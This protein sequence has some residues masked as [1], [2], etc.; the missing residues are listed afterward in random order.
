MPKKPSI[1]QYARR[2]VATGA[3][4]AKLI[5]TTSIVTAQ[6]VRLKCQY[7]CGGYGQCLTCP[8]YSPPPEK[9]A[10]V[11]CEYKKALLVHGDGHASIRA[12][13]I[14]LEREAFLD[15]Y[16]K[17]FALACGPCDLCKKCNI[18]DG[19]CHHPDKARPAMEACGIDVFQTARN[20]GFPIEVVVDET[21]RQN[22]YGVLLLE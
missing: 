1:T 6:W 2:A 9:T 15:G 16:Y 7:G 13:M 20:N 3:K 5:S 11:L 18:K 4:D 14:A 22:Y 19:E 17:A 12:I 10:Q 8:P 21:C